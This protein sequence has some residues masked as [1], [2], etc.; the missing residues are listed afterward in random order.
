MSSMR[1]ALVIA[2]I[3][4][5]G[6]LAAP[7]ARAQSAADAEVMFEI[8]APDGSDPKAKGDAPRI[9]ATVIGAPNLAADKFVLVDTSAKPPVQIPAAARRSFQ[10]GSQAVA[11]AI[12]MQG[13][14]MWI[15]NDTYRPKSDPT[16]ATGVLVPLGAAI[17]KLGLPALTPA[18]S[19]GAVITYAD[20]AQL[21]VPM[22]PIAKLTGSALGTQKD[23]ANTVGG[24]LVKGVELALAELRKAPQPLK[25]LIVL[26]DGNDANNDAAKAALAA[27]KKQAQADRVRTFA[28]IYKAGDSLPSSWRMRGSSTVR[29]SRVLDSHQES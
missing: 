10:Q 23:Y 17:D 15:G 1:A 21:R 7:A 29:I 13:W 20:R 11:L 18:G 22:G 28:I 9:E 6:L 2:A 27:L 14:E 12:V 25:V 26:S 8:K 19:V 4:S 3:G 5:V 16:R 24:E